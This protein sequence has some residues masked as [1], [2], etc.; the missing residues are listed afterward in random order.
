MI[1][2]NRVLGH[3]KSSFLR[4]ESVQVREGMPNAM[5]PGQLSASTCPQA[6]LSSIQ[7]MIPIGGDD[8]FVV[9]LGILG[10]SI[11]GRSCAQP[12]TL[13][14]IPQAWGTMKWSAQLC[15]VGS[16]GPSL[17]QPRPLPSQA[18]GIPRISP[19]GTSLP[20]CTLFSSS[21][22]SP[23]GQTYLQLSGKVSIFS[24]NG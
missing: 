1:S 5:A 17:A 9:L 7:Q 14:L 19:T 18:S 8:L 23:E 16:L 11:N 15:Q 4:D 22:H 21:V 20:L 6:H 2:G 12:L 10:V 3:L 24:P 13:T